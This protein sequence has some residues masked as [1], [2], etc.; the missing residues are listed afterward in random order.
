MISIKDNKFSVALGGITLLGVI[1]LGVAGFKGISSYNSAKEN[2]DLAVDDASTYERQPLYPRSE[3]R[4]GKS[5]ALE[6]YQQ[7]TA[8][9]QDAFEPFRPKDLANISPQ[10]FTDQ[11]VKV[12]D[13]LM[14][15]FNEAGLKAPDDFFC[16]FERYRTSLANSESTGILN[17]QLDG[18][19]HI[20][21][22]L[23]QS[24]ATELRNLYRQSLPE[25]EGGQWQPDDKNLQ[26]ARAMPMEISFIASEKAVRRFI[27]AIA[28][29]DPCFTVIRTLRLANTKQ[30]APMATDAKF[31]TVQ[32][33]DDEEAAPAADFG[34]GFDAAFALPDDD[35]AA[36]DDGTTAAPLPSAAAVA[37]SSRILAQVLGDE[38]LQVHIRL[39][40][41][42]FLPAVELP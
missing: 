21:L 20:M 13:E 35:N 8:E 31:D 12:N 2:F 29:P 7:A 14:A 23:A 30:G 5:K 40:L 33:A 24:G 32:V 42:K 27:S 34:G 36:G 6:D 4:D 16:G 25:E 17:Y 39:D 28:S 19:R 26:V 10:A 15:A 9:L 37:D 38:E 3:N 11:L 41:M 22:A 18:I 1:V